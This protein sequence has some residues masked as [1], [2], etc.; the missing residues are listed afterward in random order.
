MKKRTIFAFLLVAFIVSTVPPSFSD[1]PLL[2]P[3]TLCVEIFLSS[4]PEQLRLVRN[5]R[6][7]FKNITEP[8]INTSLPAFN[9]GFVG[10]EYALTPETRKFFITFNIFF[11]LT[12]DNESVGSY[13]NDIINEFFRAYN[14]QELTLLWKSQGVYQSQI[15]VHKSFG[16]LP[17]N[18]EQVLA[19]LKFRPVE[20]FGVLIESLLDKYVP[21]NETT[22]LTVSYWLQRTKSF[23][24][25][26]KVTGITSSLLPW[27]PHNYPVTIDVNELLNDN[28]SRIQS[29]QNQQVLISIEKHRTLQLTKGLTTYNTTIESIQPKGYTISPSYYSS[30]VGVKY[31]I[32]PKENII[33]NISIDS[34]TQ[35]QSFQ[36]DGLGDRL[37]L[38][39]AVGVSTVLIVWLIL[40]VFFPQ[41]EGIL[42]KKFKEE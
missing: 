38:Y 26:L 20:G 11:N 14:Y 2:P 30:G 18:K 29:S 4:H 36:F 15:V 25:D 23:Q 27:Y 12:T 32:L 10:L 34:S 17:L 19:F 37:M 35:K 33:I 16:Y 39:L 42:R 13:A 1:S 24:W 7:L 21:G 3:E 5:V 22:G 28:L 31:E 41:Y 8:P 9:K 40:R 6:L